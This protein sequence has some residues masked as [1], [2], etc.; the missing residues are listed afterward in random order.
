[1][2]FCC[3][4]VDSAQFKNFLEFAMKFLS[5]FASH[6]LRFVFFQEVLHA[7]DDAVEL[8][9]KEKVFNNFLSV[10]NLTD[11]FCDNLE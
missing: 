5:T 7:V 10:G 11:P 8:Y 3:L 4:F 6:Q 9:E 2:W 1:M